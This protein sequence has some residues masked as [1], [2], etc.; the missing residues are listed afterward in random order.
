MNKLLVLFPLLIL[1]LFSHAQV[2]ISGGMIFD[3]QTNQT[4]TPVC[5]LNVECSAPQIQPPPTVSTT[6]FY[7]GLVWELG[8]IQT[9]RSPL[10]VFGVRNTKS[11]RANH[12]NGV[13]LSVRFLTGSN[14]SME[15]TRVTILNGK[16]KALVQIGAGYS[17]LARSII[18]T[19]SLQF[20]HVRLTSDYIFFSNDLKFYSEIN[21]LKKPHSANAPST[22]CADDF[23]FADSTEL[24]ANSNQTLNNGTCFRLFP[25]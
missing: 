13:D 1:P 9:S 20:Q 4:T 21:T 5:N 8:G 11:K 18:G 12:V 10:V 6:N 25:S 3:V 15:S 14:F 7:T 17:Y 16:P 2:T 23:Y 19:G 24:G 22:S